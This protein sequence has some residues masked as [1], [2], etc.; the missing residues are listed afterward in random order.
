MNH[1]PRL[2][3]LDSF[4]SVPAK[5]EHMANL[6]HCPTMWLIWYKWASPYTVGPVFWI[7][8]PYWLGSEDLTLAKYRIVISR[9]PVLAALSFWVSA[10]ICFGALGNIY[11]HHTAG[12][13]ESAFA[14][15]LDALNLLA[16]GRCIYFCTTFHLSRVH[17][18]DINCHISL[19]SIL[20]CGK[21]RQTLSCHQ[22][23]RLGFH[24]L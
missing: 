21:C 22:L 13:A 15:E 5:W 10:M 18:F 4:I 14:E 11:I 17:S 24:P 12:K 19:G 2:Q 1:S 3:S 7:T 16:S 23:L 20:P 8:L 6:P 9:C